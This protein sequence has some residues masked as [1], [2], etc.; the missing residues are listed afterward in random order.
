MY[1]YSRTWGDPEWAAP[2]R[3]AQ[4]LGLFAG[5]A[6]DSCQDQ[7]DFGSDYF[8][9]LPTPRAPVRKGWRVARSPSG[10]AVLL[11]GWIDNLEELS[12]QLGISG[13]P[14]RIYGAAVERWGPEADRHIV[15]EYASLITL[16]DGAVRLA[17]SPWCSFPLFYHLGRHGLMACS[18]VRPMFAAGLEKRLRASEVDRLLAFEYPDGEHSQFEQ[19]EQVPGGA[20][21]TLRREGVASYAYYD[22]LAI[23]QIRFRRDEDYVEAANAMLAESV[24]KA[25]KLARKPAVTLSGGLDSAMVCDEMLRQM[26]AGQKLTSITFVPMDEWSGRTVNSLFGSDRPYVEEF[27]RTHPGLDP[28]FTDNRD[29]DFLTLSDQQFMAANNGSPAR[30]MG[31]VHTGVSV[32]AREAGCDWLFSA[33]IGNLTFSQEAPWAAAEFF[34][35]LQW[36]ELVRLQANRID[37]PRP[38]WR[39]VIA[40]GVMPNLPPALRWAVRDLVHRGQETSSITNPYL[41]LDGA[42][43]AKLKHR[44]AEHNISDLDFFQ[45]RERLIRNVYDLWWRGGES[46]LGQQQIHGIQGRDV[47][48]YRPF[49]E[50]CLGMPT[51]QFVRRGEKRFLARRMAVGRLPEAQRTERRHGDHVTDW[52]ERMTPMLPRL[53]EEVEQIA[54]HPELGALLDTKAMLRDLDN[55]PAEAPTDIN[56]VSRLRF[57]LPAMAYIRRYLDFETGRNPQ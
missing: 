18:I 55:W 31:F 2:F 3:A 24:A 13:T 47:L 38:L 37:D 5:H 35:T 27:I 22:P 44:N 6:A 34:R 21:V 46:G 11:I 19:I 15:G 26:P 51:D 4:S 30:V 49:I 40:G 16:G 29:V 54:A 10:Q 57:A 36:G 9:E 25:L 41:A 52:H 20:V 8:A 28:I 23:P 12:A 48:G 17:R 14:E 7:T 32:A 50:L 45:S 56:T 43:A 33:G 53:R 1:F 42:L 39:R